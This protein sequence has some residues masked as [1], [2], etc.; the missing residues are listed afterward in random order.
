MYDNEELETIIKYVVDGK[1]NIEIAEE[2]SYSPASIK[3]RLKAIYKSYR[4]ENRLELVKYILGS[5]KN[6][7]QF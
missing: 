1:T 6:S 4:V 7:F 3:R 2:M 5:F